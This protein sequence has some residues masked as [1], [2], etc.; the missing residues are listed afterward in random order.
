MSKSLD[1]SMHPFRGQ[2][3]VTEQLEFWL[4]LSLP[5]QAKNPEVPLSQCSYLFH[6]WWAE[7][8]KMT[9]FDLWPLSWGGG[10]WGA[11]TNMWHPET[12]AIAMN[13][14][15][16]LL[17]TQIPHFGYIHMGVG[18]GALIL[19]RSRAFDLFAS[20]DVH[21][22]WWE[23]SQGRPNISPRSALASSF[24]LHLQNLAV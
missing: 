9:T 19:D 4:S 2:V 5:I 14:F 23:A 15:L 6:C 1:P 18:G 10:A 3:G 13:R 11:V 16:P 20:V 7:V 17:A 21:H 22:C 12:S 8:G 24:F